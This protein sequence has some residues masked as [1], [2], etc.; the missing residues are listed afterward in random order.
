MMASTSNNPQFWLANSVAS[1]HM[2][3]EVQLLKLCKQNNYLVWFDE[4]MYVIQDK[5]MDKVLYKGLS[6]QGLYPIPFVLPSLLKASRSTTSSSKSSSASFVGRITSQSL[7]HKRFGHPAKDIVN[8]ML[9]KSKLPSVS[10]DANAVCEAFL[11]GKFKKLPFSA[12][13]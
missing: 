4:F 7:W 13:F 6:E 3:S 9:N 5:V 11:L 8:N 1:N 2:T 10:S 12:R